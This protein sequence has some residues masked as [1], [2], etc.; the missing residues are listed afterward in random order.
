MPVDVHS[1]GS[2][3]SVPRHSGSAHSV[4]YV[5]AAADAKPAPTPLTMRPASRTHTLGDQPISSPPS[6]NTADVSTSVGWR[7]SLLDA[8]P[9]RRVPTTAPIVMEEAIMPVTP[10]C[11]A[12]S[13]SG[14]SCNRAPAMMPVL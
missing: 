10:G 2:V 12:R 5:G 7:P 11:A 8:G 1:C 4:M 9:D 3:L 6:A 14:T 13:S